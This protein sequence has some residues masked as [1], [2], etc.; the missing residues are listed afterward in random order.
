MI[1]RTILLLTLVA[2][3]AG[4]TEYATPRRDGSAGA[5]L[6]TLAADSAPV[7]SA[8]ARRPMAQFPTNIAIVRVQS[9][10]A[11]QGYGQGRYAVVSTRDVETADQVQRLLK[12]QRVGGVAPIGR[13]L[14]PEQLDSDV[15]LRQAAAQLHADML[16]IYTFDTRYETDDAF[17]PLSIVSL[18]LAPVENVKM[19]TTASAILM[20]THNGYIYGVAE[21]SGKDQEGFASA[22]TME[23]AISVAREK[24]EAAAFEGLLRDFERTWPKIVKAYDK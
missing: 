6:R 8:L 2:S 3:L 10:G 14:L 24:T 7:A 23:H 22:L 12:L 17:V 13:L 16:L 5:D 19:N 11:G 9:P 4:C 20:D 15:P 18:G 21:A 1:M